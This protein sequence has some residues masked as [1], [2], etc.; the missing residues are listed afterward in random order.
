MEVTYN[1]IE[2]EQYGLTAC[3]PI[4]T[5]WGGVWTEEKLDALEKYIKAD[6]TNMNV[7]SKPD[8]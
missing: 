6:S 1:H 4:R 7:Q 2:E 3:E 8:Y 5:S